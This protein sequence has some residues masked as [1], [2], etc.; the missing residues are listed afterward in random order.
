MSYPHLPLFALLLLINVP[1]ISAGP[2]VNAT[3]DLGY[4]QYQG[5][6]DPAS[7]NT[8]FLG[9]R[10][11][12]SP[13][14]SFRWEKPQTPPK[15]AGV[16][17]ADAQPQM[18]LQG[19]FGEAPTDPF[20]AQKRA[21]S[22]SEDCLF[23]NVY[24]PANLRQ[25]TKSR[26][27]VVWIHG[28]GYV[29]GSASG[30][31]GS[32]IY[33]GNDLIKESGGE[34][35]VVV[36]QYRLG[37]FGF[38]SGS[39][40]KAGGALNA[41]LL[42]QQ[43]AL[44]WVQD[45]I[46][47]FG[48]DPNQVTIWGESAGAGSVLMHMIANS[49]Q[50]HPP[51]FKSAITSSL[52]VASQ[53]QFNDTVPEAVYTEVVTKTGC[54][55]ISDTLACLRNSSVD[56]LVA[57]NVNISAS[58]FYGTFSM[59]PVV[60]G[61]FIT[62]RPSEAIRSGKLNGKALLSVTNAFEGTILVNPNTTDVSFFLS[63]LFP[64]LGPKGIAA[65]A[66]QYAGLGTPSFQAAAIMGEAVIICPTHSLLSAFK[67]PTY[68]GEFAIGSA[69]HGADTAYYFPS[70]NPTGAPPYNNTAFDT[71]FAGSFLHFA[72]AGSP[73]G[74]KAWRSWDR[75]SKVEM[76]FNSTDGLAGEPVVHP[77]TTSAALLARCQFWDGVSAL[78]VQ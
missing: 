45:H 47:L 5:F 46:S 19:S 11:A 42:D 51:L 35:V 10:Y 58:N 29:I 32:D 75:G 48:G 76:L 64:R 74:D 18:C 57:A 41:G 22:Q 68:K 24:V 59:V 25:N 12:A 49:G 7:N 38:L 61:A 55:G 53:Y 31:T 52:Y 30:Y 20:V 8:N 44:Q 62:Q 27:V 33:N 78:T 3:V 23:L 17:M 15:I 67:G 50:T 2:L 28:G 43:F 26:P 14:G 37:L 72:V 70:S 4:A 16:Q 69:V 54:S 6:T 36:L 13:T 21:I 39:K 66:A 77:I 60:D 56:A 65:A 71:A 73:S 34:A 40:V 63:Q 1:L 9:I